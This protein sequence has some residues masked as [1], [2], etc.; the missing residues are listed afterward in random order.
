MQAE[1]D[2]PLLGPDA[3]DRP[4]TR[5]RNIVIGVPVTGDIEK[6]EKVGT[7]AQNVS[8][9]PQVEFFEERCI[10]AAIPWCT[11]GAIVR[12]AERE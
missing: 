5:V 10:D 6:V 11:L 4:E 3:A 12:R 1:L 7:E 9:T 2:M 8:L